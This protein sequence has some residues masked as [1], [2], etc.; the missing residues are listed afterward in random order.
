[1]VGDDQRLDWGFLR[2]EPSLRRPAPIP[3]EPL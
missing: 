1:M 2:P 3:I